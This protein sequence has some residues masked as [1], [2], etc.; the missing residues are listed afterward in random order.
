MPKLFTKSGK[1]WKLKKSIYG[2]KQ[3]PR[4]YF[5]HMKSK[6]EKLGFR[7]SIADPCLFISATV[8]CLIYVDDALLVYR[9]PAS[10]DRLTSRMKD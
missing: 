2:L 5:L 7:Q 4:N 8:V 3:S 9:N 10:V 1:V 6:L